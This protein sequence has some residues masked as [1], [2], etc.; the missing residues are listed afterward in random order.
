L[1]K[2][3]PRICAAIVSNDLEAVKRVEPLVD[4]FEVR[5]DL[6]GNSWQE[7]VR[8]LERPWIACNRSAR[9]GGSWQG[10]ESER[11]DE[12]LGAVKLGADIVDIELSTS[13]V[14]A[15]VK[16]IKGQA[17][18]LL[19]YHDLEETPPLGK[20]RDIV[21]NQLKI[22]ADIC[23]LITTARSFAD[24]MITL[25]LISELSESRIVAFAMGDLGHLSRVL[26]P[27]VGGDFTYASIEEGRE[28]APGQITV[29][30]LRKIYEVLKDGG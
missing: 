6:I 10:S 13:G 8:H 4:L 25:Q 16:E 19:S 23:K 2:N 1:A 20:I 14:E 17:D 9:E 18:C 28:S 11:I 7:L 22:G 12:L 30:D 24:N 15:V 21:R 5:I 29:S 3:K 26:C 27:L